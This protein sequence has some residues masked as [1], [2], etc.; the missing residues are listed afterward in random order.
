MNYIKINGVSFDANVA[1]SAY[2]RN[3]NVLDGENAGRTLSGR[4]VRDVIG[5]YIG[6]NVTV[7]RKG[8]NYQGLD[9]FWD[10]LIQHSTDDSVLLEAAD[11]QKTISYQAYYTSGTQDIEKVENG[12]NYW[13]EVQVNFIPIDAQYRP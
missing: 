8:D 7:F 13:G 9:A 3:F 2:S 5:T 10:Y 12:I 6:H 11:G 1:I 4:M